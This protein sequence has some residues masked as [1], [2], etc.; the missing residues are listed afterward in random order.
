[1]LSCP[2]QRAGMMGVLAQCASLQER[3]AAPGHSQAEGSIGSVLGRRWELCPLVPA[4]PPTQPEARSPPPPGSRDPRTPFP[5]NKPPPSQCQ[6]PTAPETN[7]WA[8]HVIGPQN[9]C[10][11]LVALAGL[12]GWDWLRGA[13]EH[14]VWGAGRCPAA[15][16]VLLVPGVKELWLMSLASEGPALL[17]LAQRANKLASHQGPRVAP[18]EKGG[19]ADSVAVWPQAAPIGD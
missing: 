6:S 7:R 15:C 2:L 16:F 19:A 13:A 3:P 11:F 10:L 18:V 17:V 4:Q 14:Q 8:C 5:R 1:M 12:C 9:R